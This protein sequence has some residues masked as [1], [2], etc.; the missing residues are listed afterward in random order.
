[1]RTKTVFDLKT[2][3]TRTIPFTAAENARVDGMA[4]PVVVTTPPG[5]SAAMVQAIRILANS[6]PPADKAAVLALLG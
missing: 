2:R 6:A 1:M 4:P 5:V 3:T